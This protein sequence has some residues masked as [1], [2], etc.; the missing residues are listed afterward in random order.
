MFVTTEDQI[1]LDCMSCSFSSIKV[2]I[3]FSIAHTRINI[4]P[5]L[6]GGRSLPS[7]HS[8]KSFFLKRGGG[9][10]SLGLAFTQFQKQ[11]GSTEGGEG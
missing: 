1:T 4:T 7:Q 9:A 8:Q 10:R 5:L 2:S 3:F 11:A 6:L